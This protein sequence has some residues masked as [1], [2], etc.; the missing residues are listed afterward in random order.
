MKETEY[1]FPGTQ[2]HVYDIDV[3]EILDTLRNKLKS[4]L[5]SVPAHL[6]DL[7]FIDDEENHFIK[8][9]NKLGIDL[10]ENAK[11]RNYIVPSSYNAYNT[12][13]GYK[14]LIMDPYKI[15]PFLSYQSVLFLGN[16]YAPKDNF[17]GLLEFLTYN[18]VNARIYFNEFYRLEKMVDWLERNRVFLLDKAYNSNE[19]F[20]AIIDNENVNS[21][22]EQFNAGEIAKANN[23]NKSTKK[24]SKKVK[25]VKRK[26]IITAPKLRI[27]L[28]DSDFADILSAKL[29]PYFP[30]SEHIKLYNLIVKD[31]FSKKL[32]F[33]GNTNQIAELFKRFRYSGRIRVRTNELLAKWI[34]N[35]F[36]VL[37]ETNKIEL[38]K[39]DT[40]L[41]VLKN[42]KKEAPK[43]KRILEE[44]AQYIMPKLRRDAKEALIK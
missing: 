8:H 37:N 17:L 30:E 31:E 4:D 38:L 40:I 39:S 11:Y 27:V 29:Q 3:F 19:K 28:M 12:Y 15:G 33:G 26:I 14:I 20:D 16:D 7:K 24:I 32:S 6:R 35:N 23:S 34:A 9:M 18:F 21:V 36:N 25:K 13:L 22:E 5:N 1:N 43:G 10:S 44:M 41:A 42:A 2:R